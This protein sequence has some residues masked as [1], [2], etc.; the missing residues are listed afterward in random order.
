[1]LSSS[2]LK[3]A[4][5]LLL[6]ALLLSSAS[7]GQE[8]NVVE[9]E[10]FDCGFDG[11]NEQSC[12]A[13]GCCWAPIEPNPN[14]VPWCYY[15]A[16]FCQSFIWTGAT[17]PGFDDA[18]VEIM[19]QNYLSQL[20]VENSGAVVAAPDEV[21]WNPSILIYTLYTHLIQ[22]NDYRKKRWHIFFPYLINSHKQLP[23][24]VTRMSLAPTF[25]FKII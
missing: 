22:Y 23:R 19:K 11:V 17:G 5:C 1:M 24:R 20:N 25:L 15:D 13:E 4:S 3:L 10:R 18:T 7:R 9:S 16:N 8:C 14:N 12:Q 21:Q 6:P 2:F